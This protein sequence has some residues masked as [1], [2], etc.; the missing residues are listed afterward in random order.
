MVALSSLNL[1]AEAWK[2]ARIVILFLL[3]EG[4]KWQR[5]EKANFQRRKIRKWGKH[6]H[7]SS[8]YSQHHFENMDFELVFGH[9]A[10][11]GFLGLK[12][13]LASKG[14]SHRELVQRKLTR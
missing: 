6:G 14:Q 4:L 7:F 5:G 11:R 2:S 1:P 9:F 3:T 13:F 10:H 12:V 8:S